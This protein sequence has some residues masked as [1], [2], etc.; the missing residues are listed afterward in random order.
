MLKRGIGKDSLDIHLY[1]IDELIYDELDVVDE[2]FD[3]ELFSSGKYILVSPFEGNRKLSVYSPGEKVCLCNTFGEIK[4]YEVLAIANVPSRL[5]SGHVH[6]PD[7]EFIL[8][9]SEYRNFTK[10]TSPMLSTFNVEDEKE[11]FFENQ[12]ATYCDNASNLDYVSRGYYMEMFKKDREMYVVIGM[13]LSIILGLIG[14]VNYLNSMITSIVTRRR[15]FALMSCVGMTSKQLN[16]MV[17]AEGLIY[18][19]ITVMVVLSFGLV[20]EKGALWFVS[21]VIGYI[22]DAL[23]IKATLVCVP[24]LALLAI[25]VPCSVF[26]TIKEKSTIEKLLSSD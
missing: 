18:M 12:L 15:E 7:P 5:N 16:L 25:I 22:S 8:P 6:M 4:E 19:I 20:I 2:E 1:G 17:I 24:L 11:A 21:T 10:N 13:T 9:A 14:I 3:K 26:N 23:Q